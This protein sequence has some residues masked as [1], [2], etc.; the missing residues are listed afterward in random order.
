MNVK[1]RVYFKEINCEKKLKVGV[2]TSI[3]NFKDEIYKFFDKKYNDFLIAPN[4]ATNQINLSFQQSVDNE[5]NLLIIDL[6]GNILQSTNLKQIN[7]NERITLNV[8][9]LS[10]GSYFIA[11]YNQDVLLKGKQFVITR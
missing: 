4:P 11:V 8:S 3:E 10:N 5:T 7:T 2:I 6:N 1:A 9:N